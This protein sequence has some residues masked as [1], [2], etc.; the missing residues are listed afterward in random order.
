[1]LCK[2][3]YFK[4]KEQIKKYYKRVSNFGGFDSES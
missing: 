1:M 2:N 4:L 3:N